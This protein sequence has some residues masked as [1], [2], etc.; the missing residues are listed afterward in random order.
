MELEPDLIL[1]FAYG[2]IVPKAVLEAPKYGCLN[3]H[4]SILPKYRGASPI[5]DVYKRQE[6]KRRLYSSLQATSSNY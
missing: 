2:Q 1:T 6:Y 3:F 4:G 5:Q